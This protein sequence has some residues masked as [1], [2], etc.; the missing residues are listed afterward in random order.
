MKNIHIYYP[1]NDWHKVEVPDEF[2][3]V[4]NQ[5]TAEI[6]NRQLINSSEDSVKNDILSII[7]SLTDTKKVPVYKAVEITTSDVTVSNS[8]ISNSINPI[9]AISSDNR[10]RKSDTT[11]TIFVL[12][13]I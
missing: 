12:D 2:G 8:I 3:N 7:K 9:Q 11:T 5:T 6:Q 13:Y 1:G 10:T 4:N